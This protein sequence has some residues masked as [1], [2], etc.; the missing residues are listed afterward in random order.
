MGIFKKLTGLLAPQPKSDAWSY[1]I[2][3]RCNR[4]GE[5]IRARVDLRN[6]LS[7]DYGES[8]ANTSY[9]CRK[10]LVGSQRCYQQIEVELTFDKDHKLV[11]KKIRGGKWIEA[12]KA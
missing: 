3:V 2:D 7:I 8:D 11:D 4:C 1:W 10:V 5:E 6:D 9:F 12:E